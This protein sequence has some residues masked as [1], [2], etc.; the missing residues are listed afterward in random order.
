VCVCACAC[1]C[2]ACSECGCGAGDSGCTECGCCRVCAEDKDLWE[3]M[4]QVE[5]EDMDMVEL[6]RERAQ[7]RREKKTKK[8]R[9]VLDRE[10]SMGLNFLFGGGGGDGEVVGEEVFSLILL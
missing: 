10:N 3:G 4:F 1:V 6:V 5:Q 2:N 8:Q 7:K 9:R